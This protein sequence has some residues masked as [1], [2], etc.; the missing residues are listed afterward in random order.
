[1]TDVIGDLHHSCIVARSKDNLE[2]VAATCRTL[3]PNEAVS[4][5]KILTYAGDICSPED[6]VAVREL[7]V[8]GTSAAVPLSEDEA[9]ITSFSQNGK[10]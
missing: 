9:D 8:R 4:P 5:N 6:M 7:I 3:L 10:V 2:R 1:M